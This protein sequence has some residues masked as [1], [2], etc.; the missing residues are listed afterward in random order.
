MLYMCHMD[1]EDKRT[2]WTHSTISKEY[3]DADRL[4]PR[5]TTPMLAEPFPLSSLPYIVHCYVYSLPPCYITPSALPKYQTGG[6][7]V[8]YTCDLSRVMDFARCRYL[9]SWDTP[10]FYA[11]VTD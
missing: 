9:H 1:F 8:S 4:R 3:L 6:C 7:S 10:L 2:E 5:L 11:G